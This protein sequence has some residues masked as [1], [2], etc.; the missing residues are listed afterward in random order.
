[1][2]GILSE[3]NDASS[4]RLT[5]VQKAVLIVVYT[6]QTPFLAYEA[7]NGNEYIVY[8]KQF[9][10]NNGL[11]VANDSGIKISGSGYEALVQNGLIDNNGE[12]TEEGQQLSA[13]FAEQRAKIQEHKIDFYFIRNLLK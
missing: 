5:A 9:L 13:A 4:L 1:M 3:I 10:E 6:A 12:P 7:I 8:A 2:N 11:I